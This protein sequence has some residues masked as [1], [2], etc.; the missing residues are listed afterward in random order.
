M[1]V[2]VVFRLLG[3]DDL[4]TNDQAKQTLYVLDVWD[5]GRWILP[6][7]REVVPATKPPLFTWLAVAASVPFGQPTEFACRL[8][9]AVAALVVAWLV[10]VIGRER[11]STRA[12]VAAAW[13][14]ATAHTTAR[15][16]IHVRP[17]MVLTVLSTTA[18]FALHRLELG[19]ERGMVGLFWTAAS[20]SVL[21]K[22]PPGLLVLGAALAALSFS[23]G[24]RRVIRERLCSP[25]ML[26]ML[27]PVAWFLLAIAAGGSE[28]LKGTVLSQTIERVLASGS[29]AGKG[30][31]PGR[32]L[33][34]FAARFAP[35][36]IVA[37][38]AGVTTFV[39]RSEP[40][41]RKDAMLVAAWLF[42]GLAIFSL[43][44]GQ[45]ED[46][47]LPLL[48]AASL[49]VALALERPSGRVVGTVW[50]VIVLCM[51]AGTLG[52]GAAAAF[53]LLWIDSSGRA[54][55][56]AL[57]A[58]SLLFSAAA[59]SYWRKRTGEDPGLSAAF[60]KAAG[61]ML[62]LM[63]GYYLFLSP[64]A[65]SA[66]GADLRTFADKVNGKRGSEDEVRLFGHLANGIRF[67][68]R[69]NVETSSREEI[70]ASLE[71][72]NPRGK[73]L[74]ITNQGGVDELQ[75]SW[76]GV[77]ALVV[78]HRH[79]KDGELALLEARRR[80]GPRRNGADG[81]SQERPRSP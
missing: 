22:G 19:R 5:A 58:S 63:V 1:V 30:Q 40:G 70:G 36:S 45:R 55:G 37:V 6:M 57:L 49:L 12:G 75:S 13:I 52:T 14:L 15:L 73:L 81:G 51:A 33:V 10:F 74:V 79:G 54:V 21:A 46:Y 72:S 39:K 41:R 32:L 76:P 7:E 43:S 35:W 26:V 44:R 48:P 3:P 28:Y 31:P 65:R 27:V 34:L 4:D 47:L 38:L 61:G 80:L 18:L 25:W 71:A 62:I 20:L 8:P 50:K 24:W 17:D 16:A 78:R 68:T 60:F 59:W 23:R 66:K 42:G 2:V 9:S 53:R 69:M 29:R 56:A 67:L 77:F 64:D 11:W